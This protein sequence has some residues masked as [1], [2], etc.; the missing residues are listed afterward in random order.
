M[1]GLSDIRDRA[2]SVVQDTPELIAKGYQR[3][4][5]HR[6]APGRAAARTH[7]LLR[8]GRAVAVIAVDPVRDAVVLIRQFRIAAH[9][10]TGKGELIEVVAGR[11]DPGE[12]DEAAAR[13]ECVEEIGVAPQ[14]L[15]RLFSVLSTPGITDEYVTFYLA[16]VDADAVPPH[17]GMANEHEDIATLVTPID[18]VIETVAAGHIANGLAVTGLQWLALNRARLPALLAEAG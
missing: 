16:A 18:Q 14:R 4:E 15:V 7:D 1:S 5:R 12:S 10:A 13:R 11:L 3:Y 6:F 2:A 17:A 8:G 9:L